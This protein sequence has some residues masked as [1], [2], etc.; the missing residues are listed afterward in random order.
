MTRAAITSCSKFSTVHVAYIWSCAF[1]R[2]ASRL[3]VGCWN[4]VSYVYAIQ[5]PP[6]P[7]E[8]EGAVDGPCD[9]LSESVKIERSES[10]HSITC[11]VRVQCP[12]K[13]AAC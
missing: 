7:A 6:A 8:A 3:A 12:P 11:P 2:D 13:P 5:E 4:G 10:T 9:V 1:S